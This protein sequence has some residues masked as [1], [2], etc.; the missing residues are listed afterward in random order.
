MAA[1]AA[2]SRRLR[3]PAE[4]AA[5]VAPR[6]ALEQQFPQRRA[7]RSLRHLPSRHRQVGPRLGRESGLSARGR[8]HRR[9]RARSHAARKK[10]RRPPTTTRSDTPVYGPINARESRRPLRR[11]APRGQDRQSLFNPNDVTV[12]VIPRAAG[13]DQER[14]AGRR[15]HRQ[16]RRRSLGRFLASSG[17]PRAECRLGQAPGVDHSPRRTGA[18]FHAPALGS[19]RR[20]DEPAQGRRIRLYHLP[21]RAGERHGLQMGVAHAERSAASRRVATRA[22]L[23][24]QPSL[25]LSDASRSL[26]GSQLLEVPS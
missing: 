14:L 6:S 8:N 1:G 26:Q 18:V 16:S 2:D 17:V 3:R 11:N 12:S 22:W 9:R 5:G 13:G 21:R 24:Q 19:V 4:A 23:V 10:A 20:L 15:R 25:D 7:L